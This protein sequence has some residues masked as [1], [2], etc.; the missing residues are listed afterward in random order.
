DVIGSQQATAPAAALPQQELRSPAR[1]LRAASPY[2][3]RTTSFRFSALMASL[4]F[5]EVLE[6]APLTCTAR[7]FAW[8]RSPCSGYSTPRTE[9]PRAARVPGYSRDT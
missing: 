6:L 2:F 1:A 3:S 9:T 4:S 7:R 8:A 5:D